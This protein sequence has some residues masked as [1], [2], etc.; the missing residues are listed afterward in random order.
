ML[1]GVGLQ[2]RHQRKENRMDTPTT[3]DSP[4]VEHAKNELHRAGLDSPDSDYGGATAEAVLALIRV[5]AGQGHS[6]MS[7]AI[8]LDVFTRLAE[9]RALMPLTDDPD[10]WI[11]RTDI[12]GE[13]YWQNKRDS[14]YFST[15]GGKTYFMPEDTNEVIYRSKPSR[16]HD[17]RQA[18][19]ENDQ[20]SEG[21]GKADQQLEDAPAEVQASNDGPDKTDQGLQSER[22]TEPGATS[23]HSSGERS[24]E[25][26]ERQ[27]EVER[28]EPAD[29]GYGTTRGESSD[30][31]G[32]GSPE[33]QDEGGK[34]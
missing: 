9:Y 21:V 25:V 34:S 23:A 6:G 10:E 33:T 19:R 30:Q 11:D 26:E 5:F 2:H 7:A 16:R 32:T 17:E 12:M 18:Q 24:R 31:E 3:E 1:G 20:A 8:T 29:G 13:P 4:L 22:T 27:H 28:S 14:K 15:D